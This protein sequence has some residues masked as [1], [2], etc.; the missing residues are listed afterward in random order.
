MHNKIL[1]W[2]VSAALKNDYLVFNSNHWKE[3]EHIGIYKYTTILLFII[4]YS[5]SMHTLETLHNS[6]Q[7]LQFTNY[8]ISKKGMQ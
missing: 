4:K 7:L 6:H 3:T 8:I 2:K 1:K 5:L